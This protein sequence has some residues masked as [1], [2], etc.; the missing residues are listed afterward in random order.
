MRSLDPRVVNLWRLQGLVRLGTFW[1][2]IL[3]GG[4]VFLGLRTGAIAGTAV[5]ALLFLLLAVLSVAWPSV[6]W[7]HFHFDVRD[8]DL[9]VERGVLFRQSVAIPLDRI[10]HVDTRQ[11]PLERM[12]G[13]S[14]VV[15][16]TAAGMNADGS[17][18]GLAEDD[19]HALRDL[20]ARRRGD[21]G[22]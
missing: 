14:R 20:L 3:V 21:D 11:G 5:P 6:A 4:G 10:Q 19:A 18:P 13:L 8:R 17:I 1:L 9:L 16:Y 7:S 2:P 22:V 15:V 12:F